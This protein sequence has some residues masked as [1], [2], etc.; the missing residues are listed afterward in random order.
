[1][2]AREISEGIAAVAVA[3]LGEEEASSC[4]CTMALVLVVLTS[5][6]VLAMRKGKTCSWRT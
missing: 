3:K 1:V 2:V 6:I 5:S 4:A